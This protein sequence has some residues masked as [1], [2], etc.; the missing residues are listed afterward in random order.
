MLHFEQGRPGQLAEIVNFAGHAYGSDGVPEDFPALLPKLYG[1]EAHS[2]AM[3]TLLWEDDRLVGIFALQVSEFWAAGVPLKVG[4]IGS[5]AVDPAERGRGHLGRLMREANRQLERQGCALGVLGGQRQRYQ[6]FGYEYGGSQWLFTVTGRNIRDEKRPESLRVT[7]LREADV[8]AALALYL[9]QPVHTLRTE[10]N[11]L[12]ILRSWNGRPYAIW[13]GDLLAG[14]C[15]LD[16]NGC[17]MELVLER[18]ELLP[19]VLRELLPIAGGEIHITLGPWP[20]NCQRLLAR[21]SDRTVLLENHS[22]RVLDWD[23]VLRA[24]LA[25]RRAYGFPMADGTLRAAVG[26]QG[27]AVLTK[28]GETLTCRWEQGP[29]PPLPHHQAV[30]LLLGADSA[31]VS[32]AELAPPGWLPLPLA[33][34]WLDG[35]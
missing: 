25:M 35:I 5:V 14:Y 28:S 8:P 6:V 2:E 31:L 29:E 22:Y 16:D 18:A 20:G 11:F 34:P 4:W 27:T 30:R 7:E 19:G 26:G 3:H 9:R 1:P 15:T 12:A 10:K 21:I 23:A 13:D 33:F 32:G 24:A 17:S